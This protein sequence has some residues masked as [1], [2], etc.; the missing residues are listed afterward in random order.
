M[1]PK[2][3]ACSGCLVN[4]DSVNEIYFILY[5]G[6]LTYEMD[7]PVDIFVNS[8]YLTSTLAQPSEAISSVT[9]KAL[10]GPG[11]CPLFARRARKWWEEP[12]LC[13]EPASVRSGSYLLA[14]HNLGFF[15]RKWL[16]QS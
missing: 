1:K 11:A 7:D 4:L 15:N 3:L 13:T 8:S 10:V 16:Q 5:T 9:R 2:A 6:S 12:R 14:A